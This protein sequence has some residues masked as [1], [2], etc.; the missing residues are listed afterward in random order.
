MPRILRLSVLTV[1]IGGWAAAAP[2]EHLDRAELAALREQVRWLE[3]QLRAVSQRLDAAER[4]PAALA[5]ATKVSATDQGFAIVAADEANAIKLRGLIAADARF[6]A[7]DSGHAADSLV[8][9]RA[10]LIS[11]GRLARDYG[12]L[13]V[14]EFGGPS[15]NILDAAITARLTPA[16]ELKAGKFK[17]PVGHELLQRAHA[18]AFTER[19]MVSRLLPGR[20]VGLQVGGDLAGGVVSYMAGLFNGVPDSMHNTNVDFDNGQDAAGRLVIRPFNGGE[21]FRGLTFGA[22]A[23]RGRHRTAAGRPPGYPSEGQQSYFSYVPGVIADGPVWRIAP[24]LDLRAGRVGVMSE[25]VVSSSTLRANPQARPVA[26]KHHGWQI[27]GGYVLT[28]E[29]SSYAGL[30]PRE[31]FS[32]AAGTWGAFEVVGRVTRLDIDDHAFPNFASSAESASEVTSFALGLNWHWSKTLRLMIDYYRSTFRLDV[33]A[34]AAAA[35]R[36][37]ERAFVSRLQLSF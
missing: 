32:L 14:T 35:W 10:R 30:T 36:D 13:F 12:F 24:N 8:L 6:F 11:E 21:D 20:D 17:S 22:G 7:G 2:A 33:A 37:D 23:S 27:T 34:P 18:T 31:N 4:T 9:R 5:G 28:G 29:D 15:V 26:L 16:I 19:S 1:L 3:A 25:Y